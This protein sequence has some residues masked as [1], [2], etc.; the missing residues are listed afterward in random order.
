[1][2]A[3]NLLAR[4]KAFTGTTCEEGVLED[5]HYPLQ[6]GTARTDKQAT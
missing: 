4:K 1:M 3:A 5:T 2:G 6:V